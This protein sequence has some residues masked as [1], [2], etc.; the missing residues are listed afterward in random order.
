MADEEAG[1]VK[2]SSWLVDNHPGL[3]EGVDEAVSEVGGFS[4]ELQGRRT[5]LLQSAEKG[6]A[7]C[8]WWPPAGPGTA[9][10]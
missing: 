1:G 9:R 8:V 10:R 5:Y 4:V 7:G 2:G 3:F 6:I